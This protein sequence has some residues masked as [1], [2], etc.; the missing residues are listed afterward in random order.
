MHQWKVPWADDRFVKRSLCV[1]ACT[2][3]LFSGI[4]STYKEFNVL[5]IL[6]VKQMPSCLFFHAF[7]TVKHSCGQMRKVGRENM[8]HILL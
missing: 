1:L 8:K 7:M 6:G 2:F 4:Y 3:I 5:Y